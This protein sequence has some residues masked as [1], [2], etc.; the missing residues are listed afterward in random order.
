MITRRQG[1]KYP[2]VHLRSSGQNINSQCVHKYSIICV[3]LCVGLVLCPFHPPK[4]Y[5]AAAAISA[6][7]NK[8]GT[9]IIQFIGDV[10]L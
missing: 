2:G 5:V 7:C 10:K 8:H 1:L 3:S 4:E 6:G 9:I